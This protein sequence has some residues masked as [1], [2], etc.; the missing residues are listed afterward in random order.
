MSKTP[1][2]QSAPD[3]G[4]DELLKDFGVVFQWLRQNSVDAM[5][6]KAWL[7]LDLSM[8]QVK[9][10]FSTVRAGRLRSK[11]LAALLGVGPPAVTAIVDKLVRKKLLRRE[12]D[13]DDRRVVWLVPTP[14]ATA[15]HERL[16][17]A[18]RASLRALFQSLSPQELS[19][20]QVGIAAMAA[21]VAHREVKS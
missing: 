1:K 16:V 7:S 6:Q 4:L 5:N 8:P 11:E 13:V 2:N 21:A 18:G 20:V 3:E 14:Q 10:L 17:G 9:A 15:L 19:H 12:H